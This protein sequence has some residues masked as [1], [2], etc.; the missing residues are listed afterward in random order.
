MPSKIASPVVASCRRISVRPTV[1]LPEPDSPTRP[2]VLPFRQLE[3]DVLDRLE[4]ALAEQA[5]ARIEILAEVLHLEHDRIARTDAALA[6]GHVARPRRAAVHVVVDHRQPHR[7]PVELRPA[8]EQRLR[9]GVARILEHVLRGALLADLAVAHHDDVVGDLAHHGQIVGDE[10]HRHLVLLLQRGD[11]VED[12]LLDRHVE[13]RRRLVGD[14]QLGLA[15][16]RHR[17]HHPLLLAAGHLRWKRVDPVLGIGNADFLEQLDRAPARLARTSCPCAGAAPRSSWKPTVNTGFSEVIGSWKIIE[18][19][20]PRNPA[21][22]VLV[23][24]REIAAVVE[25]LALRVDD[26]ILGR[27]QPEDRERSDRLAAARLADQ[28]DGRFRRDVERDALDR[29]EDRALVDAGMRP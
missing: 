9:V 17:D 10:Q 24:P 28:R 14:Q 25:D 16:D 29:L 27:Q 4:L 20:A 8:L 19:S 22:L 5:L 6:L 13:R 18:M 3:R 23:E 15:G 12:L 7:P 21:Q 11:E 1:V 2:S 26:R